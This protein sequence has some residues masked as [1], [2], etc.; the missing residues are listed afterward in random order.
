MRFGL[1]TQFC[2]DMRS[3]VDKVSPEF[4]EDMCSRADHVFLEFYEDMRYRAAYVSPDF[5]ED[6]SSQADHGSP[7]FCKNVT[8]MV[9]GIDKMLLELTDYDLGMPR[10]RVCEFGDVLN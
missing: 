2:E 6:M 8:Y 1:I 4:C 3:R 7:E 5:C 9:L 10:W